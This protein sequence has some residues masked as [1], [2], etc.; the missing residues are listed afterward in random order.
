MRRLL[1][2]TVATVVGL[3]ALVGGG[4]YWLGFGG[5]LETPQAS[6]R[7]AG[8]PAAQLNAPVS[9]PT[10]QTPPATS[11]RAPASPTAA[12]LSPPAPP[13][14]AP[15]PPAFDVVRVAPDGTAVIA[16]RAAPGARVTVRDGDKD[17]GTVTA[18][19]RGEWVLLPSAPLAPGGRTLTLSAKLGE[20]PLVAAE[21]DVVLVVPERQKDVAGQPATQPGQS[22]ALSVPRTG[23]TA[24][25]TVLQAPPTPRAAPAA[26]P[27]PIQSQG[28]VSVDVIDYDEA[29]RVI[30]S[31]KVQPEGDVRVYLDNRLVGESASGSGQWRMTPE[32]EIAAGN[33]TLR[34]DLL[35]P[36]GRVVARV[37]LPF[38]RAAV[39]PEVLAGGSVVVQPGYSL[40]R[41]ARRAYGD[42]IRYTLIYAANAE[43]IRDPDLI[44]PGQVFQLPTG[45]N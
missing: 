21:R 23:G 38:Q 14:A 28:Q 44:Y 26:A 7:A 36:G 9:A 22:L 40:W 3:G 13:A 17:L 5:R 33:Y 25:S 34:A 24:P 6:G 29:G 18:D 35:G 19:G 39:T 11:A 20:G 4:L 31:G 15:T 10:P 43:Q 30:F 27:P 41:I 16:G 8:T 1:V 2:V 45:T 42:G 37:E 32:S 12:A